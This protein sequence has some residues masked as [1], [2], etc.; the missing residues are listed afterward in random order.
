MRNNVSILLV[1]VM[2]LAVLSVAS[3]AG[4]SQDNAQA[5]AAPASSAA[6]PDRD[7]AKKLSNP[8][9]DLIS[10]PLQFNYDEGFGA[11]DAGFWRLN[12]QP[13][14]PFALTPEVNLISRTIVPVVY[15]ES[16]APGIDSSFGL[17][18]TLQSF[19][20]SPREPVGGWIVGAGP[21]FSFPTAT[22]DLLGSEKW[23]AGPTAVVLRQAHGWTYGILAN[24]IWSF[25]G[26][27]DRESVNVSFLQ[28]FL[29]YTT[30][31][32]TTFTLNTE[33]TYDWDESEW[34]IPLNVMVSQL[35]RVG[36]LPVSVGV[37]GRWYAEAPD[38]G[39]EWGA[40]LVLTILLPR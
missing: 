10:I 32:A 13:V 29:A 28:P 26:E 5:A 14:I 21:A 20:V 31:G 39:P 27:D 40:R 2:G 16:L 4:A 36:K 18:D 19:F 1:G 8:V 7:L 38:G 22:D 3:T 9:A 37:G 24:H 25:A 35:M 12:V 23:G 33:S 34:T 17:G 6:G 11:N 15:Q 30:S